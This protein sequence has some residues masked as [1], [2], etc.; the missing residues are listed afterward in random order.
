MA[1][2]IVIEEGSVA[3]GTVCRILAESGHEAVE[4]ATGKAGI[5]AVSHTH[6]DLVVCGI[7]MPV[8]DGGEA[9][10]QIRE[11]DSRVPIIAIYGSFGM[12]EL[13][14]LDDATAMGATRSVLKPFTAEQLMRTVDGLL[15][16]YRA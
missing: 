3:R 4:A 12:G 1:K 13:A 5:D 16:P 9:I 11:L 10:Q 14:R 2:V 6:F 15:D 7:P 8:Q